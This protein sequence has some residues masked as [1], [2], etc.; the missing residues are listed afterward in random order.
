LELIGLSEGGSV[1]AAKVVGK[2]AVEVFPRMAPTSAVDAQM[3]KLIF[4]SLLYG[5]DGCL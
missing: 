2:D 5:F 3:L 4:S 1:I